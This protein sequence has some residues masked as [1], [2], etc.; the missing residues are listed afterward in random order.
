MRRVLAQHY[1]PDPPCG[2]GPSWLSFLGHMK[3]S[4][5]SVDLFR[6]ESILMKSHRVLVVMD[7]FTRQIIGFAVQAGELDGPALCRMFSRAVSDQGAPRYLSSDNDPLFLFHRWQANLRIL[8]V[9]EVKTIP[10]VPI[11]HPFIER[12]I[13]TIRREYLDHVLFWNASDLA[14]KLEEFQNYYNKHRVRASLDGHTPEQMNGDRLINCASLD[15]Y[16]WTP[17]CHGLFQMP[18]AV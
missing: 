3:D 11:S 18:V 17:H 6:C 5:W 13:G 1:R 14:R 16:A 10:Y 7:Q 15:A 4:L 9:E 12:L 2:R 8:G